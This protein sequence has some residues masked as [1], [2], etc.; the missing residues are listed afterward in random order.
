MKLRVAWGQSGRAPGAFDAVRTWDPVGWGGSVAFFPENVGNSSLGP[1]ITSEIEFGFDATF[2]NDKVTMEFTSYDQTTTNALF[3]VTQ[4][5][6]LGFL[7]SRR[8]AE[9]RYR[10]AVETTPV[11][12]WARS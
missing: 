9:G 5:P 11:S 10:G 2:L 4:I 12:L 1:E 8:T 6:S 7:G 3:S